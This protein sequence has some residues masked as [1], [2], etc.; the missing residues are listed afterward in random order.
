MLKAFYSR[1]IASWLRSSH[2]TTTLRRPDWSIMA[3]STA[4][5]NALRALDKLPDGVDP[6][7]GM[8]DS[9]WFVSNSADPA[10]GFRPDGLVYSDLPDTMPDSVD[11]P[12]KWHLNRWGAVTANMVAAHAEGRHGLLQKA[13]IS[14]DDQRKTA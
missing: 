1:F 12:G 2:N 9:F 11:Q 4:G 6:I 3:V 5:S 7:G 13:V 14:A 10:L 8:K